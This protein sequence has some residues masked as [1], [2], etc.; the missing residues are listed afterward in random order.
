VMAG[1]QAAA[2][3]GRRIKALGLTLCLIVV[4]LGIGWLACS[5][6]ERRHGRTVS[7][8]LM[9][10]HIVRLSDGQ[11]IGLGRSVL[12]NGVFCTLLIVPTA[13][14]CALLGAVFMLGASLPD[15]VLKRPRSAPWDVLSGTMVIEERAEVPGDPVGVTRPVLNGKSHMACSV[16]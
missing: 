11:P 9:G 3:F 8:R 7:Y 16:G 10:L 1:G 5:V 4:M 12:R 6:L 13:A 15:D 14:V 2:N